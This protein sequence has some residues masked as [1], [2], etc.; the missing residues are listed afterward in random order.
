MVNTHEELVVWQKGM[1][2]AKASYLATKC[3]PKEETFGL[4]SQIRRAAVS[5]PANIA[6]GAG[7]GG[8]KEFLQFL[9]IARGSLSEL[10][11]LTVLANEVE[12]L[13]KK[14]LADLLQQ[15]EEVSRLIG[16][17]ITSLRRRAGITR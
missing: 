11:T 7:R 10:Q 14:K 4:T 16:G 12:L 2:L 1:A 13:E 15:A 5:I 3:F 8:T 17:L 9:S 6:E